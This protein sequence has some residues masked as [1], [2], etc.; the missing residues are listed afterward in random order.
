MSEYKPTRAEK[1]ALI[2]QLAKYCVP[3]IYGLNADEVA[4]RIL[5][6]VNKAKGA[7]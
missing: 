2:D 5:I 6:A 1:D 4:E 3:K 7:T